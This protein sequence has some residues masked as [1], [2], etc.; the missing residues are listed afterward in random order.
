M[1]DPT[2]VRSISGRPIEADP[3][4]AR[5]KARNTN[6]ESKMKHQIL[7]AIDVPTLRYISLA[8]ISNVH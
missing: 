5:S 4:K 3:S 6:E 2:H 8:Q 1:D 7:L